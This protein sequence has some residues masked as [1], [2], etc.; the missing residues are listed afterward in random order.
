MGGTCSR[1]RRSHDGHGRYGGYASPSYQGP[2]PPEWRAGVGYYEAPPPYAVPYPY[3]PAPV[4]Q[5]PATAPPP[6]AV[7]YPYY[8]APVYHTPATAPEQR[9][10]KPQ[11]NR[12]Y[13]RI[14]DDY[15]SVDQ[16]TDSLAR[17]GLESSNLIVGIDFTKSNEWTGKFSFHR[18]SLHHI[19]NTPNPYE[20]A[21]SII[22]QT[23]AKFDEDN[24]I[25]CFGFGDASTHDQDAFR[26]YP[27]ERPYNGFTEALGRYRELVQHLHL[28]RPTL[29]IASIIEMA[30]TIWDQISG[31]YHDAL[32]TTD[33]QIWSW[34][35]I[36]NNLITGTSIDKRTEGI[37]LG[38]LGQSA[39]GKSG[40]NPG[41]SEESTF[42]L[43][44]DSGAS[45]HAVGDKRMLQGYRL[46]LNPWWVAQPD[47]TFLRVVG[48]GTLKHGDHFCIPAVY[49]V[50]G[51]KKNLISVSQLATQHGICFG[52][53]RCEITLP[54]GTP[55]GGA[56]MEEQGN[57]YVLNYLQIPEPEEHKPRLLLDSG[58]SNHMVGDPGLLQ[59]IEY[60][61]SPR[62]AT[63]ADGSPLR[64][65]GVG[66]IQTEQFFIP[67]VQLVDGLLKNL[68]SVG[69]L[70]EDH[71]T[72]SCFHSKVC[73]IMLPDGTIVGEGELEGNG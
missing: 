38:A 65:L 34:E 12:R 8:P 59:D 54:D 63:Q 19:S 39:G 29:S 33:G 46:L 52:S 7:P 40:P 2:P 25:P 17:A 44:L 68:I 62:W 64:V 26:Y 28:A 48:I 15:H 73:S 30:K 31:Q 60:F 22:G 16:V 13:S 23:L 6:Y 20:Q 43:L 50:E 37:L 11:L 14:A 41:G 69:Q 72:C 1:S 27:D 57:M 61:H 9:A 5:T 24:L 49:H 21:I 71:G 58:A 32:I 3:C 67:K 70:D 53:K 66:T 47:G 45:M 36:V 4:Y 35:H 55:V 18:R 51:L 56:F 10:E 42:R